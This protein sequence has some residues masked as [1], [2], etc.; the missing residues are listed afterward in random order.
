MSQNKIKPKKLQFLL[1][2]IKYPIFILG[3]VSVTADEKIKQ[4][5]Q[6]EINTGQKLT[7]LD[8]FHFNLT[9]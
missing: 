2:N 7:S 6:D 4:K 3:L 1:W 8:L 9:S 5:T